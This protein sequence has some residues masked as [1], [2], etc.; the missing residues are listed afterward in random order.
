MAKVDPFILTLPS[1]LA[2]DPQIGPFFTYLMKFLHDMW[3]RTGAGVDA[4]DGAAQLA[5]DQIFAGDNEFSGSVNLDSIPLQV[6][7]VPVVRGQQA[8]VADA[9]AATATNPSA[10]AA[11]TA[12][13]SGGAAL[14]SSSA[15]DFTNT[16][17][18]LQALR[19]EV[20]TYEGTISALIV[21]VADIRT[22]LNTALSRLRTHGLIDT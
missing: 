13:S 6:D 11:Y 5:G 16:A 19:D 20:A 17:L 12:P 9:A 3:V 10:P 4:V 18:S 2:K 21:D 8:A 22:Q 15:T 7:G 14:T 1:K